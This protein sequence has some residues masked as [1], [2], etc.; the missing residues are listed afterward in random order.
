MKVLYVRL[1]T[2]PFHQVTRLESHVV[3]AIKNLQITF[4]ILAGFVSSMKRCL[5]EKPSC[6]EEMRAI[7]DGA[8]YDHRII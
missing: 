6:T 5:R 7:A 2:C 8:E 4:T 1:V 3:T